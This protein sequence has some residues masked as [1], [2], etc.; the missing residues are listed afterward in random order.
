[1]FTGANGNVVDVADSNFYS[2]YK[3]ETDSAFLFKTG[4][5]SSTHLT[6][7]DAAIDGWAATSDFCGITSDKAATFFRTADSN[8]IIA[9]DKIKGTANT[10]TCTCG[11]KHAKPDNPCTKITSSNIVSNCRTTG[12][13][14]GSKNCC[15][16]TATALLK[17]GKDVA[18]AGASVNI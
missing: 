2:C 4:A 8:Q 13:G 6:A 10:I 5:Q 16:M 11:T 18:T 7:G 17:S 1:M 9:T 14:S 3:S 15:L 12:D